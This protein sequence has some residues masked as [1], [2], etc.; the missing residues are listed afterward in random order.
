[1]QPSIDKFDAQKRLA[2]FWF[3]T[4]GALAFLVV[5]C[6]TIGQFK[7]C[8]EEAWQWYAQSIIPT[9][10]LIIGTFYATITQPPGS[11]ITV[12]A[13]YYKFCFYAS[14][15]YF[16]IL[17]LIVLGAPM[18]Y[19]LAGTTSLDLLQ[20]SKTYLTIIQGVVSYSLGLFFVKGK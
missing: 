2:V 8:K 19:H 3:V 20:Q 7:E 18:V 6:S 10:T 15:F 11:G 13:F 17:Y 16:L 9:L 5:V 1:M 12:E 14:A 4:A